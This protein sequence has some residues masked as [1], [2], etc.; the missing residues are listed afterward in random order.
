MSFCFASVDGL[1]GATGKLE[2]KD[3]FPEFP[4]VSAYRTEI[5]QPVVRGFGVNVEEPKLP[6][7]IL[8]PFQGLAG[9]RVAC[10][11]VS[12]YFAVIQIVVRTLNLG[13][14]ARGS[15]EHIALN[16]CVSEACEKESSQVVGLAIGHVPAWRVAH[17]VDVDTFAVAE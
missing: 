17:A 1:A 8:V 3:V 15:V 11:S 7:V 16:V 6:V 2:S 4:S 13:D 12:E 5:E 9:S 10:T 14:D